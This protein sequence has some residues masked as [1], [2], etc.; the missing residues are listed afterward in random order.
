[1]T[2]NVFNKMS[3]LVTIA[4]PVYNAEKFLSDAIQSVINQTYKNWI[5]YL[6]NDGSTDNS[7]SIIQEFAA[8]DSRI[9]IID[10]GKNKGLPA[11]L[12][13]SISLA[14]TKYYARMDADDIM[15]IT[16]I[17]EQV[18]FLEAHPEIDVLGTSIMTIDNNNVIIGSGNSSGLVKSF[19][20]P[21]IIGKTEWFKANPYCEWAVRAEDTELWYRTSYKSNFWSLDKPLLFYREFGIPTLNK[22]LKSKMTLLRIFSYYKRYHKS[23]YWFLSNAFETILKMF[24]YICF[25]LIGKIDML[26]KLRNR[27]PLHDNL[28]LT[29]KDLELSIKK[30]ES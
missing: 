28:C 13:E 23:L 3:V 6:I 27:N 10:D 19:F 26:V 21:T 7:S 9:K 15:Y 1:M 22:Y 2:S 8:K 12:N 4:I 20:H 5:L 11:R 14:D 25:A 30:M 18:I 17:E 24:S 29:Q 16:R